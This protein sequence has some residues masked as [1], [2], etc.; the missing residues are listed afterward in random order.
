MLLKACD[1]LQ[2]FGNPESP[3]SLGAC[4]RNMGLLSRTCLLVRGPC[5]VC[6]MTRRALFQSPSHFSAFVHRRV[7]AGIDWKSMK[8]FENC[9]NHLKPHTIHWAEERIHEYIWII[10]DQFAWIQWKN[11]EDI[12]RYLGNALVDHNLSILVF[13]SILTFSSRRWFRAE[14]HRPAIDAYVN[15]FT[16][17]RTLRLLDAFG[18]SEAM[19]FLGGIKE[20]YLRLGGFD[21]ANFESCQLP[22]F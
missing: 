13:Y 8:I 10:L 17:Q 12:W 14:D 6:V 11:I 18:A 16:M 2:P 15:G 21:V 20:V 5:P 4:C 19:T 7:L 9:I 1:Q 22:F 3:A